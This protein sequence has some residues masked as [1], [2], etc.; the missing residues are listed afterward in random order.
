M[1]QGSFVLIWKR[2]RAW[3][4]EQTWLIYSVAG[5]VVVPWVLAVTTTPGF[6]Q[7]LR[8]TSAKTLA[9]VV[10]C[11]FGWG[12]GAVLSGLGIKKVG[13]ALASSILLGITASFGSL[14]PLLVLQPSNLLNRQTYL[15]LA[16]LLIVM[17]GL[18]LCSAAGRRRQREL[19]PD[20][21]YGGAGFGWGLLI[22]ICSGLF[23]PMINFSFA[24]GGELQRLALASGV[25]PAMA[26]NLIWA[27]ALSAGFLVNAGYCIYL[28]MKNRTW[29]LFLQKDV[30]GLYWAGAIMMGVFWFGGIMFYGIGALDMGVLGAAIGWPLFMLMIIITANF[31]GVV[32][33]EWK[34][35][36]KGTYGYLAAGNIVLAMAVYVIAQGRGGPA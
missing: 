18:T 22:C 14:L 33:G 26:A 11:G 32:A 4:F 2:M 9:V 10:I 13:M 29:G 35:V 1:L 23:S 31:C 16:G 3:R 15:L 24:F 21:E 34:G 12:V 20:T 19:S 25:K 28:L 6:R 27:L 36:S 17:M 30:R 5:F 7:V 8:H